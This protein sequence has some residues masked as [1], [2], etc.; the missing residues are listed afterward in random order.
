MPASQRSRRSAAARAV[1]AAFALAS[2]AA[3]ACGPLG[4]LP[5][6]RLRGDVVPPPASWSEVAEAET[7]QLETDPDDPHSVNIWGAAVEGRFYVATSLI[8]G[9][10]EPAERTWVRNVQRDPRVRLRARG[11][12]FELRAVRVTAGEE[13]ERA[14]RALLAKYDVE[15]DAH[16]EAAWVF[17]LEPR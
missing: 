17:R 2:L 11:R 1:V 14:R 12:V 15:R 16:A 7:F 8:L 5:G 3:L 4:P 9:T 6:G 13:R 10:D